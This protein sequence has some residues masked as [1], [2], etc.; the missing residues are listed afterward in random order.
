MD[1]VILLVHPDILVPPLPSAGQSAES[2]LP[3]TSTSASAIGPEELANS[4]RRFAGG[5]Q[6]AD[7]SADCP[8]EALFSKVLLKALQLLLI[9]RWHLATYRGVM[10]EYRQYRPIIEVYSDIGPVY[11]PCQ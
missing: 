8:A 4:K 9:F 5:R 2:S 11:R 1:R 3:V 10:H 7:N 6:S